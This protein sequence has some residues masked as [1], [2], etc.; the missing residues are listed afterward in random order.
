MQRFINDANPDGIER[1][2]TG[3]Y[4]ITDAIGNPDG[5]IVFRAEMDKMACIAIMNI[6]HWELS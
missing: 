6:A 4:E 1:I 5:I 2:P 3:S